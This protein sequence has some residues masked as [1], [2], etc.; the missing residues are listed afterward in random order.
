[1]NNRIVQLYDSLADKYLLEMFSKSRWTREV[2]RKE[3]DLVER[4]LNLTSRKEN[5]T[6]KVIDLGMGPGRW[7]EFLL[8]RGV[9]HVSGVDI[10]SKMVKAAKK[11]IKSKNFT[12]TVANMEKLPFKSGYF[13]IV[14]C[15]RSF[16]YVGSPEKAILEMIRV[17]KPNGRI[18]LE[19]PNNSLQLKVAKFFLKRNHQKSKAAKYLKLAKLYNLDDID[20]LLRKS[21]LKLISIRPFSIL[22]AIPLTDSLF[23][24]W[25]ILEKTLF[26]ILPKR[27][28]TRS[29]I[30]LLS[31]YNK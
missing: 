23:W 21:K 8:R 11:S 27:W 3:K 16:K 20:F 17:L 6:K 5:V 14:F 26:F 1:M 12:A 28:F 30:L 29:W 9:G 25:V 4:M 15:F 13:D 19:F 31:K 10:S 22:P 2:D 24:I 7:S 18:L